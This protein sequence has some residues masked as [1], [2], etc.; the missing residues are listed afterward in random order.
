MPYR[1]RTKHHTDK[2]PTRKPL[3]AAKGLPVDKS[4][5]LEKGVMVMTGAK[6]EAEERVD[7]LLL[8]PLAGLKAQRGMTAEKHEKMLH[9]LRGWLA[10]MS[11]ENLRGMHDLI[12]RHAVKGV[13]PAEA[14]IKHWATTLQLPPP[15][16]CDYARSLIR[17]AMG[18]QAREEG[19]AVELY[20]IAKRIGPPPTKYF[21]SGLKDEAES[22]RRRRIVVCEKIEAGHETAEDRAWLARWHEDMA[23]VEAIQSAASE[24]QAA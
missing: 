23:E 22:N 21:I 11:A 16:E 3:Q 7:A 20:Q 2:T 12:V 24:G 18:R 5:G 8:E 1:T 4:E 13:W 10:Y 14:L 9:R 17:S 15:R 19:W 6:A